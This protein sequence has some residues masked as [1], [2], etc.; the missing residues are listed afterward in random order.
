MFRLWQ[1]QRRRGQNEPRQV[2]EQLADFID[3]HGDSRFSPAS[4]HDDSHYHSVRDRAGLW[5]DDAEGRVYLFTAEGMREA[6]KGFDFDRAL[7]VLEQ[8]GVIPPPD[9]K[10][11]RPRQKKMWQEHARVLPGS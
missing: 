2:L 8:A 11:R 3:R 6:L 4:G 5:D 1:S 10:G 9:E 7:D